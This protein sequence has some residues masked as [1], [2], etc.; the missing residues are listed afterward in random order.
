MCFWLGVVEILEELSE[1]VRLGYALGHD[2]VLTLGFGV[3]D[4][5]LVL[6]GP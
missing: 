6:G 2:A 3:G 1:P 5:E 4:H